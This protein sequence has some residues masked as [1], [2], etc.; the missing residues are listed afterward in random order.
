MDA[1]LFLFAFVLAGCSSSEEPRVARSAF[2]KAVSPPLCDRFKECAP[3]SFAKT[4][5]DGGVTQCAA[6]FEKTNSPD[7][8]TKCTQ[9]QLDTCV[10]DVK[11][12]SCESLGFDPT[13]AAPSCRTCF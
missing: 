8:A 4:Y 13:S 3:N 2:L 10:G 9:A 7:D 12:G 5:P 11:K 1:R 6:E